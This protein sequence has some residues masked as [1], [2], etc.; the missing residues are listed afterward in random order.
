MK[1]R[2]YKCDSIPMNDKVHYINLGKIYDNLQVYEI[3][4]N[5]HYEHYRKVNK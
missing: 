3:V 5:F 4:C 1:C 2:V